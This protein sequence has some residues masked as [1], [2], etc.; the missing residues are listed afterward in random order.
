MAANVLFLQA[1]F[2]SLFVLDFPVLFSTLSL[3]LCEYYCRLWLR[4]LASL[5]DSSPPIEVISG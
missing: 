2:I 5:S 3:R 1:F 4:Y